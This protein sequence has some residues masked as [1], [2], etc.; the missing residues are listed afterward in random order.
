[1]IQFL[2]C[3]SASCWAFDITFEDPL[4]VVKTC[5]LLVVI[6]SFKLVFAC[7]CILC[8]GHRNQ[9]GTSFVCRLPIG[10]HAIFGYRVMF[11]GR[12]S[13]IHMFGVERGEEWVGESFLLPTHGWQY[14]GVELTAD[15][16]T[17]SLSRDLLVE[18]L[19][20]RK[21]YCLTV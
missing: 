7:L 1:M 14:Q 9:M 4:A 13:G 19:S 2:L 21:F 10:L 8:R 3:M 6:D 17:Q 18:L 20:K 11:I 16:F 12:D 15:S 5:R